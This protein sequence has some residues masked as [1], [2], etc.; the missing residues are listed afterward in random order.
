MDSG[1]DRAILAWR[2]CH[3]IPKCLGGTLAVSRLSSVVF[4][5]RRRF[6]AGFQWGCRSR[7]SAARSLAKPRGC[8]VVYRTLGGLDREVE[9]RGAP[10]LALIA[11]K[12][13]RSSCFK[14]G[15]DPSPRTS[16][17]NAQ[18]YSRMLVPGVLVPAA[19]EHLLITRKYAR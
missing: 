14:A 19:R 16:R 1:F 5:H 6:R 3:S 17:L 12:R 11:H 8:W 18:H 13:F 7:P 10:L 15:T 2:F 9:P 4:T